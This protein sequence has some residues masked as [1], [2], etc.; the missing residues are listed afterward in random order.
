MDRVWI[1]P[2][3]EGHLQATGRDARGRKQYRYHA[4]WQALRGEDK[5]GRLEAF[6]R[7]LPRLRAQ[8]ARDLR[9]AAGGAPAAVTRR[10]LLATMVRLLDTTFVRVGNEAYARENR[11]YG[12]TTLRNRHAGVDGATLRLRFRGKAGVMQ[13]VELHD[14]RVAAVVRRCRDCRGRSC[15]STRTRRAGCTAST[16]ATS[17]TV[18]A[19]SPAAP[20][21]P[22]TSAPGTAAC[23]RSS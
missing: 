2:L 5:F 22:R 23:W 8:V 19:S 18:W 16:P 1:C 7:A 12:L 6:G 14:R 9:P 15:S 13:E 11:S 21:P 17:T 3:A 10:L 4:D 20:S